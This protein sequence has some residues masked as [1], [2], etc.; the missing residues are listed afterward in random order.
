MNSQF[1]ADQDPSAQHD[2]NSAIPGQL[3]RRD[4]AQAPG[5]LG[6]T[7]GLDLTSVLEALPAALL[8][9]DRVGRIVFV[10]KAFCELVGL[11][12]HDLHSAGA[13][14]TPATE[15][16]EALG[17]DDDEVF[18]GGAIVEVGHSFWNP[19]CGERRYGHSFKSPIYDSTAAPLFILCVTI[20]VTE[21]KKVEDG[22]RASQEKL[23]GLYELSPLGIALTDMEGRYVEFNDAFERI[24]RYPRDEL[25]ALDYWT[26]TPREYE[27][28]ELK[29]LARLAEKG[30]YGPYEKEYVRKDGTRVPLSLNG[31]LVTGS[32]GQP[33]IWS[34]VED[35]AE[36]KKKDE[37]L[38]LGALIFNSSSEGILVANADE[39]IVDVN[40]AFSNLLGFSRD[41]A[42]GR[43]CDLIKLGLQADEFA[44][45]SRA[46]DGKE[47]HEG[48]AFASHKDGRRLA[49][50]ATLSLIRDKDGRPFR[51]LLQFWD[52]TERRRKDE[53]IWRQANFDALTELPNRRLFYDRLQLEMERAQRAGQ[54]L[55]VLFIDL[56]R[57]KEVNDSLGHHAGDAILV[58][59]AQRLRRCVRRGDVVARLGGDEFTVILL[60]LNEKSFVEEVAERINGEISA[61]YAVGDKNIRLSASIGIT[62]FPDDGRD[63]ESLMQHSDLAMYQAKYEGRNRFT[64]FTPSLQQKADKR[65]SL[66]DD[67]AGAIERSELE[68]FYQPIVDLRCGRVAKAEALLRW[69]HPRRG[70]VSPAE[71]I[72]IAEESGLI[73]DI[74]DWVLD[75]AANVALHW[76][77]N[78]RQKIQIAVNVSPVQ[79]A[80]RTMVLQWAQKLAVLGLPP[81]ALALE[82]TEGLL[83][84][85]R[86][87]LQEQLAALRSI[88]VGS[89]LDDFGAGFSSLSYLKR[90]CIETLKIDRSFIGNLAEDSTDR[91]LTE[92]I[93]L[94]AKKLGIKTVA[95]GV[96]TQAQRQLLEGFGCDFAQGFLFARPAPLGEFEARFLKLDC[97]LLG[98]GL[99]QGQ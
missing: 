93:I 45:L 64:H 5:G 62:V 77:K 57:F 75:Q 81:G 69:R 53:T 50:S 1:S 15:L 72:P 94:M 9:K 91:A 31:V 88:G 37:S 71:F 44:S 61:P 4:E 68:L 28:E 11:S 33:Y 12:L 32:D 22:L 46:L 70:M 59:T 78:F 92:A 56:D 36:R 98:R 24:C 19:L 43:A 16:I 97:N 49:L 27:A 58:E 47:R 89:C 8:L 51:Y 74:G 6:R 60:G 52:V 21:P 14:G 76:A 63:A 90:F 99:G 54:C 42:T 34:L 13:A 20:D 26:L 10:N 23:R 55:T 3:A 30:C 86:P 80:E 95:E 79:F 39:K 65:L 35:I 66:I 96:E 7:E 2:E 83:I 85:D 87:E 48:D 41:E 17:C 25:R 29:Q 38:S 73:L 82:F 67:L 18:R 40:P 84:Q